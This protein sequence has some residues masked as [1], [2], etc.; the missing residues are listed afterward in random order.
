M[1]NDAIGLKETNPLLVK[2]IEKYLFWAFLLIIIVLFGY[3]LFVDDTYAYFNDLGSDVIL[4]EPKEGQTAETLNLLVNTLEDNDI[5]IKRHYS[6]FTSTTF[7]EGLDGRRK[8]KSTHY[9]DYFDYTEAIIGSKVKWLFKNDVLTEEGIY[10]EETEYLE[11]GSPELV[12]FFY[13][14]YD[15]GM[16][17]EPDLV[18]KVQ[19]VYQIKKQEK[20]LL[21]GTLTRDSFYRVIHSCHYENMYNYNPDYFLRTEKDITYDDLLVITQIFEYPN[22]AL[23]NIEE[24]RSVT[25]LISKGLERMFLTVIVLILTITIILFYQY[26]KSISNVLYIWHVYYMSFND[27][28][29]RAFLATIINIITP[30][31]ISV[32]LL[33][34]MIVFV[35][36]YYGYKILMP[37]IMVSVLFGIIVLIAATMCLIKVITLSK[38]KKTDLVSV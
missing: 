3:Q 27:I 15:Y 22:I 5:N 25:N 8:A 17:T 2:K 4:A 10:L 1:Y 30:F 12:N 32:T 7:L 11:L 13:R 31:I 38:I 34:S 28:F 35:R 37:L 19:G 16:P 24:A 29:K 23:I 20:F 21:Y 33:I 14:S 26:I 36:L 9:A 18:L 6:V